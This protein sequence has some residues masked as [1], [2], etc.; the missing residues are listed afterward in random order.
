[1]ESGPFSFTVQAADAGSYTDSREYT[2][3]VMDYLPGDLDQSLAV[4]PTDVVYIVNYVYR[5][6]DPPAF[7]NSADVDA[8]CKINPVDVVILA[9]YVYR[10]LGS[11]AAG[12]AE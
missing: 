10:N 11:L 7:P 5:Q 12:C 4:N 3:E 1:M 8:D 2:L 9:N 6:A